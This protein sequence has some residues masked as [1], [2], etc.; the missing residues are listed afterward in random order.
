MEDIS[1]FTDD[2]ASVSGALSDGAKEFIRKYTPQDDDSGCVVSFETVS[3]FKPYKTRQ[4][5][6]LAESAGQVPGSECDVFEDVTY[7]RISIRGND[8]L[9]VHRP[10][11]PED[12]R[13][14]PFAWQE[15]QRG[16][17]IV[18]NGT[19]LTNI[20]L[21]RSMIRH[22]QARNV[23]TVEDL[24]K[25]DDNNLQNLGTNA[26]EF[27]RAAKEL[28]TKSMAPANDGL[29]AQVQQLSEQLADAMAMIR[30]QKEQLDSKSTTL[31]LK[32]DKAGA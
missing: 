24:A 31:A 19:P 2:N 22:Y 14:F 3:E 16:K 18:E 20:G 32:K 9:E 15:Y 26:R 10:V 29:R 6:E 11:R 13:R 30:A 27:R 23:W 21:D 17:Q 5:Q 25:V 7:I 1:E 12:K 28:L 4:A 8:K